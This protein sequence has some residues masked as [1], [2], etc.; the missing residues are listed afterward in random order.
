[1][2]LVGNKNRIIIYNLKKFNNISKN[3]AVLVFYKL[4]TVMS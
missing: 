1:M 4:V 2:I 3:K